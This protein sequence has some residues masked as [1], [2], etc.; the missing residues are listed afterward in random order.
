MVEHKL[1]WFTFQTYCLFVSELDY[2]WVLYASAWTNQRKS[3]TGGPQY[4]SYKIPHSTRFILLLASCYE[5]IVRL[6]CGVITSPHYFPIAKAQGGGFPQWIAATDTLGHIF[7]AI[8]LRFP[9]PTQERDEPTILSV[10]A[11]EN[12]HMTRFTLL[13]FL[14]I[15]RYMWRN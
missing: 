4:N 6:V 1:T 13:L 2:I 14:R 9:E 12:T 11:M 15:Q 7:A 10:I 3:R 8:M 5:F